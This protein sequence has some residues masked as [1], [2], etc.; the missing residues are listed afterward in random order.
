MSNYRRFLLAVISISAGVF[1]IVVANF[2]GAFE[3]SL[4]N[5]TLGIR[6]R[7]A[8]LT[9]AIM[10][11]FFIYAN[12][13]LYH[14]CLYCLNEFLTKYPN[15]MS[16]KELKLKLTSGINFGL[17]Y[18]WIT[19]ILFT[20]LYITSEKLV[21]S[22]DY[23]AWYLSFLGIFF[24]RYAFLTL[25]TVLFITWF[26]IS[27]FLNEKLID[28]FGIERFEHLSD[29]V[30]SNAIVSAVSLSLIPLFWLGTVVPVIDR[31]IVA[32]IFLVLIV[33]LFRPIHKV[34]KNISKKKALAVERINHS[35]KS[36]FSSSG[37]S[38]RRLTDDPVRL[39]KLSSL[40]SSK[41]QI[42]NVSELAIDIPQGMKTLAIALSVPASWAIGALIDGYLELL[43][44]SSSFI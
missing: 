32:V 15:E 7:N 12:Q 28:L 30:I 35:I 19:G 44:K 9:F 23:L 27:H 31:V 11:A 43:V 2:F 41:Q 38:N 13:F 5:S 4:L 17:R 22:T 26:V 14:R 6:Q 3:L 16:H 37:H 18:S 24:W 36:L 39:R 40:I 10:I 25:Y 8:A 29:L 1:A 42:A 21:S 33:Y 20:I 34:Q